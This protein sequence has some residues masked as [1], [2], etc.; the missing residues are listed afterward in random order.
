MNH[1][2]PI[3]SFQR[4]QER[5]KEGYGLRYPDGHVIRLYEN[6]MKRKL[7]LDGPGQR[8]LDFGCWNGTHTHY[9]ATKGFTPFGVD[10]VADAIAEAR[11]SMPVHSANFHVIDDRTDLQP[12]I[13]GPL[14]VLFSNQVLYFLDDT[15]LIKRMA[16]F[17]AM[18][19]P[20]GVIVATM[21]S[22][23]CYWNRYSKGVWPNGLE[24]VDLSSHGRL[25]GKHYIR[26]T[27][28]PEHLRAQFCR[29]E[30]IQIGSYSVALDLEEGDAHHFVYV[31]RRRAA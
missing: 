12:L 8:L 13:G 15:T 24:E 9:F 29:F 30:T 20:G 2:A 27:E 31:G 10:I 16:E 26:F 11:Q 5:F 4:Y 23:A 25:S 14:D 6:V 28:S 1:S 21:M 18:L 3:T 22:R 7:G 19:R 17:E